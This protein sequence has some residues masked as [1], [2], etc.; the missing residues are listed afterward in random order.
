MKANQIILSAIIIGLLMAI[1]ANS[2]EH[3]RLLKEMREQANPE[4]YILRELR[5]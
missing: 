1:A 4:L 5:K 3:T 2:N